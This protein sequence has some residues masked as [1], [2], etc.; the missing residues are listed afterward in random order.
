MRLWRAG[1]S[2]WGLCGWVAQRETHPCR[3]PCRMSYRVRDMYA[4]MDKQ[5]CLWLDSIINDKVTS[6]KH[7][8]DLLAFK[9]LL[10]EHP[11]DLE[12]FRGK[13]L[14]VNN[15]FFLPFWFYHPS[16]ACEAD[17]QVTY[18]FYVPTE[19]K[20]CSSGSMFKQSMH[21]ITVNK[22]STTSRENENGV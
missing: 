3:K 1:G 8:R 7:Q 14:A 13:Y 2:S 11:D 22:M 16:D 17:L 12:E 5:C 9:R 10:Q 18:F 21:T 6:K 15:G 20:F 4:E 19:D